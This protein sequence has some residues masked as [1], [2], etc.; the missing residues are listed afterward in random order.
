MRSLFMHTTCI[1]YGSGSY[2]LS[3]DDVRQSTAHLTPNTA[4]E[5]PHFATQA[6]CC[7]PRNVTFAKVPLIHLPLFRKLTGPQPL[8]IDLYG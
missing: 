7:S 8:V 3:A 4:L 2:L 5:M 6:L 1:D